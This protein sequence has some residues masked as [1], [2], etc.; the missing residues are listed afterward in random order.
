MPSLPDTKSYYT[1]LQINQDATEQEIRKS[2]KRLAML[3]HPDKNIGD[4]TNACAAFKKVY[5]F[6]FLS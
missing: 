4:F 3:Q 5:L 1:V 6:L 2:Y